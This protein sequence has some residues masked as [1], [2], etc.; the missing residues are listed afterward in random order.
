MNER[1]AALGEKA[2][3]RGQPA[4]A[5]VSLACGVVGGTN[6]QLA[7]AVQE[8]KPSC[9][10]SAQNCPQGAVQKG[11]GFVLS[12]RLAVLTA[13]RDVLG[14]EG[15][16][17][18][19]LYTLAV[20]IFEGNKAM[21]I[22]QTRHVWPDDLEADQ[23]ELCDVGR[24]FAYSVRGVVAQAVE[25]REFELPCLLAPARA[26]VHVSIPDRAP[27][28]DADG[29]AEET[30]VAF[31]VRDPVAQVLRLEAGGHGRLH[32][33]VQDLHQARPGRDVGQPFRA[34]CR[35]SRSGVGFDEDP[36]CLRS[37]DAVQSI[38]DDGGLGGH[39][40]TFVLG[41][42]FFWPWKKKSDADF[43]VDVQVHGLLGCRGAALGLFWDCWRHG[44]V[45][46]I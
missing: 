8:L 16:P 17:P 9:D 41:D 19:A 37:V 22:P 1:V 18:R 44:Q 2:Q 43:M 25:V 46:I 14:F 6:S 27:R 7:D 26:S 11:Q 32:F 30:R 39:K 10:N 33:A 31:E 20:Q 40:S 15:G 5:P 45:E 36:A 35:G 21:Q 13:P 12:P 42:A 3:E 29:L 4:Q 38:I 28:R 23:V 34:R 24:R